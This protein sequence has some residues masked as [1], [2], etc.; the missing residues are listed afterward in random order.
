V[1]LSVSTSS[2]LESKRRNPESKPAQVSEQSEFTHSEELIT[3]N[4]PTSCILRHP[5]RPARPLAH[6]LYD[7]LHRKGDSTDPAHPVSIYLNVFRVNP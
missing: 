3:F 7:A 5:D 2:L 4:P 1:R 6:H